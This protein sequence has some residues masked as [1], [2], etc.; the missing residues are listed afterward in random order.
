MNYEYKA[1]L[2]N[3]KEIEDALN[4]QSMERGG[5]NSDDTIELNWFTIRDF[6]EYTRYIKKDIDQMQTI[7]TQIKKLHQLH[8]H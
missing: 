7:F 1:F 6:I 4:K 2:K 8:N 5:V 3:F